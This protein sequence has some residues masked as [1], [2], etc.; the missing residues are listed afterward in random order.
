[1][2][3]A[4]RPTPGLAT[5]LLAAQSLVLLAGALTTWLVASAVA[6]GIFRDHLL[7]AGV[8]HTAAETGHVDEAFASALL[9]ALAVALL[10]SIV[11]ALTVTWFFTRRVQR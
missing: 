2:T 3:R 7:R 9:I 11:F 4:R 1:M 8:A 5:R 6:P 10:V